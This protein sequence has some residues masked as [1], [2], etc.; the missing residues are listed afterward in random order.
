MKKLSLFLSSVVLALLLIVSAGCG[1]FVSDSFI[2]GGGEVKPEETTPAVID[3]SVALKDSAALSDSI[4]L[5]SA[6]TRPD[7]PLSE[8]E[9]KQAVARTSVAL[10]TS[11]FG[12]GVIVD[13]DDGVDYGEDEEK[14][15][16][17]V[18]C[19]HMISSGGSIKV[20]V[21]D[22]NYSYENEKYIFTGTIGGAVAENQAVSLV[23]GDAISDIALIK[24]YVSDL[25][26]ARTLVKAKIMDT[27]KYA[28]DLYE[29]VF[30]IGN[31]TGTLP[32]SATSVGSANPL[33]RD[34]LVESAGYM[35]LMQIAVG[36]NPGNSGG[37]LYNLYGELVGI[38][39]AGNTNYESINFAIPLKT[40]ENEGE[41]DRG[42][43]NVVKQLLAT[44]LASGDKLNY[45]YVS[46][47]W[48]LGVV[49]QMNTMGTRL[50]FL[51]VDE[52]SMAEKAGAKP[53]AKLSSSLESYDEVLSVSF[54][55]KVTEKNEIY[56]LSELVSSGYTANEAFSL[57]MSIAKSTLSE[58]D[59]F[60]VSIRR[61][62]G[63][64]YTTMDLNFS[65][66][67]PSYIFADTANYDN[68]KAA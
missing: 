53:Y 14:I 24:L 5:K 18:T 11:G 28:V 27:E 48:S 7:S 51:T 54:Y 52:G 6:Q 64:S 36:T 4:V 30:A 44:Y 10:E 2:N 65:I 42:M 60:T 43:V 20:Y 3:Y 13:I 15:F 49:V 31:P 68:I 17:I 21:P 66:E 63:R 34:V 22:E 59:K 16:Y 26:V 39:N 8:K 62:E 56:S 45:G 19:H 37:G 40:T 38:T 32:G 47:R 46:G 25:T 29:N 58:G 12:S 1:S 57:I 23:G 33:R 35:T 50:F 61:C 9:A 67:N 55:N 41:E